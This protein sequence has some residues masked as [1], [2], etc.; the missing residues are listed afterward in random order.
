MAKETSITFRDFFQERFFDVDRKYVDIS[1]SNVLHEMAVPFDIAKLPVKPDADDIQYLQQFPPQYWTQAM[2]QRYYHDLK[3]ALAERESRR[4][5]VEKRLYGLLKRALETGNHEA[6]RGQVSEEL[7]TRLSNQ[8]Y[9]HVSGDDQLADRA[10]RHLAELET[11]KSIPH[12]LDKQEDGLRPG[13]KRYTFKKS[14]RGNETVTIVARPYINRLIHKLERTRDHE[15]HPQSGLQALGQTHGQYGYDLYGVKEGG[16][17]GDPHTTRGM[18]LPPSAEVQTR[19]RD[20]LAHNA[21]GMYGQLPTGPDVVYKQMGEGRTVY[22]D[23]WAIKKIQNKVFS[24]IYSTI[25]T[26][27]PGSYTLEDGTRVPPEGGF[28][29][30][31]QRRKVAAELAKM[32]VIKMA[33]AGQ[34]RGAPYPGQPNGLPVLV[35]TVRGK[36]VLDAPPL[37]LPHKKVPVTVQESPDQPPK[38]VMHEVPMVNPAEYLRELGSEEDDD[39][40]DQSQLRGHAQ[41]YVA[42]DHR[43]FKKGKRGYLASGALHLTHNSHGREHL[44][45]S[46]PDYE[47]TKSRIEEE[48]GMT[49][50]DGQNKPSKGG[51]GQYFFDIIKGIWNCINSGC[52]GMTAHEVSIMKQNVPDLHTMVYQKMMM[53]LRSN[54]LGTPS[55]RR[56]FARN[57]VS[58]WAQQDLGEGGGSR[59]LRKLKQTARSSS[60]DATTSGDSGDKLSLRDSIQQQMREKDAGGDPTKLSRGQKARPGAGQH[61]FPYNIDNFRA[62]LAEMEGEAEQADAKRDRA[63]GM[64]RSQISDEIADLIGD[65]IADKAALTI[66]MEFLLTQLF[67]GSSDANKAEEMAKAKV[68]QY[69][70]SSGGKSKGI[71]AAFKADKMVQELLAQPEETENASSEAERDAIEKLHGVLDRLPP[72]KKSEPATQAMI[73]NYIKSQ[74][75]E[76]QA[77]LKA[78]AD[79]AFGKTP[80]AAPVQQPAQAAAQPAAATGGP[81]QVEANKLI[82][83]KNWIALS[84]NV[85]F[86]QHAPAAHLQAV[87]GKLEAE[88]QAKNG[89]ERENHEFAVEHLRGLLGKRQTPQF[90]D[91]T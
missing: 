88:M 53:S 42:V 70:S 15:H 40:V 85:Y 36:K 34:V 2:H 10:A 74:P 62:S 21:H 68:N 37:M 43:D 87:I 23:N 65:S 54:K 84:N 82:A 1:M 26:A 27:E 35:K 78:E 89:M 58:S 56:A 77:A 75:E 69:V 31:D 81:G 13:L 76:F 22:K 19:M 7:M 51:E 83:A 86:L 46:D 30:E 8:E 32:E 48:M 29:S 50:L 91:I 9:D 90:G 38:T 5:P 66:K 63:V 16:E 67:L 52:G 49:A 61:G 3:D 25:N 28:D 39:S 6:L 45:P 79:K 14:R 80:A 55:G 33:E 4:G 60:M 47:E 18:Q 24:R 11:E 73:Y 59:R 20:Y 41:D 17:D 44:D 72:D 57:V 71:V 12:G 64:S